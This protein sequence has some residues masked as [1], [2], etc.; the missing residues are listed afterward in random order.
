MN[1][2]GSR[3][4]EVQQQKSTITGSNISRPSTWGSLL[5][6]DRREMHA[7]LDGMNKICIAKLQVLYVYRDRN[8]PRPVTFSS[9]LAHISPRVVLASH[10]A[11]QGGKVPQRRPSQRHKEISNSSPL[12]STGSNNNYFNATIKEKMMNVTGLLLSRL[13]CQ[14]GRRRTDRHCHHRQPLLCLGNEL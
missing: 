14:L 6:R 12:L 7:P 4:T 5:E 3:T 9:H 10:P 13:G 8:P 2:S 1:Q 11:L